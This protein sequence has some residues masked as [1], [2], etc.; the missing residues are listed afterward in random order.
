M[1]S[2]RAYSVVG[3]PLTPL[4]T[5]CS[6]L[7][8][9]PH[10]PSQEVGDD[11]ESGSISR[12]DGGRS[13]YFPT[14]MSPPQ[15]ESLA[16]TARRS[17]SRSASADGISKEEPFAGPLDDA[18]RS[19][20]GNPGWKQL[21]VGS[22][23]PWATSSFDDIQFSLESP[24]R[25]HPKPSTSFGMPD[26]DSATHRTAMQPTTGGHGAGVSK[27]PKSVDNKVDIR[28]PTMTNAGL[29]S[30]APP[31]YLEDLLAVV[32]PFITPQPT[33]TADSSHRLEI[34]SAL[35]S[36]TPVKT[37]S[38]GVS[39]QDAKGIA[40][41]TTPLHVQQQQQQQTKFDKAPQSQIEVEVPR[42][43]AIPEEPRRAPPAPPVEQTESS[44][45]PLS[46][47]GFGE[48]R[49]LH[50]HTRDA[51]ALE[52]ASDP[53]STAHASGLAESQDTMPATRRPQQSLSTDYV[54]A[55]YYPSEAGLSTHDDQLQSPPD[56]PLKS[57][58]S[59][60][61]RG[62]FERPVMHH[63]LKERPWRHSDSL[64]RSDWRPAGLEGLAS[65]EMDNQGRWTGATASINSSATARRDHVNLPAIVTA[66]AVDRE[67]LRTPIGSDGRDLA[68]LPAGVDPAHSR[69]ASKQD[70]TQGRDYTVAPLAVGARKDHRWHHHRQPPGSGQ[71]RSSLAYQGGSSTYRV[72]H[73][74]A[75]SKTP[76]RSTNCT[77][78]LRVILPQPLWTMGSS[79]RR[80]CL[81][82]PVPG[83]G[84]GETSRLAGMTT[85]PER[86]L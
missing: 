51:S 10:R 62:S 42:G 84:K 20:I 11:P 85:M 39:A 60:R 1:S 22:G 82:E 17:L 65:P 77:S 43:T 13:E 28:Q 56:Y 26:P 21:S 36:G 69:V 49:D 45:K 9:W 52:D 48:E 14:A 33:A 44:W 79:K 16:T 72:S 53:V 81:V 30:P 23:G 27:T 32:K 68:E 61:R 67:R 83:T 59:A 73:N 74:S 78:R 63:A 5:T 12:L 35:G 75:A 7:E 86:E 47:G 6:A 37:T 38:G 41:D 57:R 25:R 19:P 50:T 24:Y 29:F 54:I 8:R 76:K 40:E 18:R 3:L 46:T 66:G 34:S 70:E 64:S 71:A 80:R 4:P 2:S 15:P 31:V 58:L 55:N